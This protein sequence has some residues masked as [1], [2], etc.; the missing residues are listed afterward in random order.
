MMP[1]LSDVRGEADGG[2]RSLGVDRR[3]FRQE[4]VA[5]GRTGHA[6]PSDGVPI[7]GHYLLMR[8]TESP[9]G[10]LGTGKPPVGEHSY[11]LDLMRVTESPSGRLGTG[12][13]PVGEHSYVLDL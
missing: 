5:S 3:T 11:V 4:V 13:P 9:S 12:K 7:Y 10:R 6:Q 8:V 2:K 1:G